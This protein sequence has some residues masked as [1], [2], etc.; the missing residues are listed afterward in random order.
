MLEQK[1]LEAYADGSSIELMITSFNTTYKNIM[2]I[3]RTYKE[4]SRTKR[5][6]TDE[7]KIM[8]AERDLNKDI[9]RKQIA[10]E[11]G[12]NA[13]TVK[14]ACEQFGQSIKE[15]AQSDNLYTRIDGEFT[16]E[17][18]PS[19]KSKRVNTVDEKTI[20]CMEC[21]DEHEIYEDHALKI[22]FEYLED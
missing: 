13:N 11:L 9:S 21:G 22:N 7:F 17:T 1:V 5:T 10:Q 3:L 8:I 12:I 20:Y 16:M 6:F 4:Q 14:R 15:K 18:C 19:C 2:E